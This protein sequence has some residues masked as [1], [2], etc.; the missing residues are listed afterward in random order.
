MYKPE[1]NQGSEYIF[2]NFFLFWNNAKRSN[3]KIMSK[4]YFKFKKHLK[5][6][7]KL[8]QTLKITLN[9]RKISEWQNLLQIS[10][11]KSKTESKKQKN[12]HSNDY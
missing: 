4:N 10:T 9:V 5:I 3:Q 6:P 11:E 1:K 7:E 12:L 2:F 8:H